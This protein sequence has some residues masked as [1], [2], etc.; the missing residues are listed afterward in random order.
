V[1]ADSASFFYDTKINK[2]ISDVAYECSDEQK[3]KIINFVVLK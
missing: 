1:V 2:K 3:Q